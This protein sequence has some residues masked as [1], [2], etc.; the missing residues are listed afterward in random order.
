MNAVTT[1]DQVNAVAA[2]IQH[3][4][5][6]KLTP[7]QK[8]DY[9]MGVCTSLGMNP[10][11][12]PFE[13]IRLGGREVLYAK[14]DAADQ[15]R[16][17]NGI[18]IEVVSRQTEGELMTV[19]VRA[20]DAA[21]RVDEDFGVV[22]I[23]GLKGEN[24]ANAI[25]KAVTKAKR[26]VTLSI[27]GLGFLDET[28]VADVPGAQPVAQSQQPIIKEPVK[29]EAK[30]AEPPVD[31]ETGEVSPHTIL[32]PLLPDSSGTDWMEW[33]KKYAAALQSSADVKELDEWVKANVSAMSQAATNASKIHGRLLAVIDA[34]RFAF[35][36]QPEASSDL[37]IPKFLDKRGAVAEQAA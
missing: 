30:K 23:A 3:N 6:S 31:P 22:S 33:G 4:D 11:T 15:L 24:L 21:G 37:A 19:H 8:N 9:Y 32:V 13:F 12:R 18:S 20:K 25:L 10:M 34:K 17:I 36:P 7:A 5:L 35:T 16:K 2:V 28:E 27:S 1:Q 29:I 26:R 14:R